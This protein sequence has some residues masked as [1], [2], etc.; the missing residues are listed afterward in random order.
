MHAIMTLEHHVEARARLGGLRRGELER[1][2]REQREEDL[3]LAELRE[4]DLFHAKL[5]EEGAPVLRLEGVAA[6]VL[7]VWREVHELV[8]LGAELLQFK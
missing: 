7:E 5:V 4:G 1:D 8:E 2:R 3:H 6:H